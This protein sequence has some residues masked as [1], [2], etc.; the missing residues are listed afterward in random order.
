MGAHVINP[1]QLQLFMGGQEWQSK[2]DDS[3]DR[4]MHETMS[5][6]WARKTAESKSE[7][8]ELMDEPVHA[9]LSREGYDHDPYD[10]PRLYHGQLYGQMD[11]P[12]FIQGEGHHRVAA[13]ADIERTTGRNVW[14]PTTYEAWASD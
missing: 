8:G 6:V 13:A 3:V 10:P 2:V 5:D 14:I 1:H 12:G 9:S 11:K 7:P 4:G